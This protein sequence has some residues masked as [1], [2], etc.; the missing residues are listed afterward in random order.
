MIRQEFRRIFRSPFFYLSVIILLIGSFVGAFDCLVDSNDIIYLFDVTGVGYG[1]ALI[2]ILSSV[3]IADSYLIEYQSGYH[4]AVMSRTTKFK[5]CISKI[6]AAIVSGI[7]IVLLMKLLLI[8]LLVVITKCLHGSFVFGSEQSV[9]YF[10]NTNI[11]ILQRRFGMYIVQ[12]IFYDCMYASIFPV[13]TLA[14]STVVKNKYVV[15]L[16]PFIYANVTAFVFVGLKWYYLT[17]MVLGSEGRAVTLPYS[18]IPFHI[19]VAV[20]YWTVSTIWFVRCVIKETK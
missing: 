19:I 11:F 4:Y 10:G 13:L 12:N 2:P 1:M 9:A 8:A 6:G 17:P 5:Y 3:T 18:G 7:L 16:F 20:I 15:M 14:I